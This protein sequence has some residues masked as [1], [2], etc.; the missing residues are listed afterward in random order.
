MKIIHTSVEE[1]AMRRLLIGFEGENQRA[2][3][4]IDCASVFA[5]YPNATPAL[6][7]KPMFASA[8]PVVV[9]R[10]GDYVDW[11]ITNQILSFSGDGEIQLVFYAG[12]AICKSCVGKIFVRRS[13]KVSGST[14][15]PVAQ[16]VD[17]AN[18]KL[19]EVDAAIAS[20]P[21]PGEGTPAGGLRGQVLA[22]ASD[23]DHD[24]EWINVAPVIKD[25]T[26]GD[27]ATIIDGADG[28]PVDNLW[29]LINPVQEG[30][31]N[32]S[33]DNIRPIH[34]WNAVKVTRTGKN[35]FFRKYDNAALDES[36]RIVDSEDSYCMVG[37]VK[38]GT[39]YYMSKNGAP[40]AY[41][42]SIPEKN[43]DPAHNGYRDNS[44][45]TFIPAI[46]GYVVVEFPSWISDPAMGTTQSLNI[47]TDVMPG[48][49]SYPFYEGETYTITFPEEA[50]TVYGGVLNVTDGILYVTHAVIESYN[51]EP[52][53]TTQWMSDRDVNTYVEGEGPSIGAQVVYHLET[54]I[55]YRLTPTQITTL[56]GV[57]NVWADAGSVNNMVYCADTKLYI[58]QKI[59]EAVKKLNPTPEPN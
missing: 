48:D 47:D 11:L 44:A 34:G 19:A 9:E 28:Y 52:L 12:D 14:P 7:V 46:D 6:I 30:E 25:Y 51:G 59:K 56:L 15:G 20:I 2:T 13:L 24:V 58:D 39:E 53:P 57:N 50:G 16:W 37:E 32:P 38:A 36:G 41:H 42:T 55:S 10:D 5:E 8:Y 22:K 45:K 33:P 40:I 21:D 18:R 29:I 23:T 1:M 26:R 49:I 35:L 27:I 31:G 54:P 17:D 43:G 3:V 4:R